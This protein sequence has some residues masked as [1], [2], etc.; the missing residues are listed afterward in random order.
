MQ[1]MLMLNSRVFFH[2]SMFMPPPP[3]LNT[4]T[5]VATLSSSTGNIVGN[6]GSRKSVHFRFGSN[7][8]VASVSASSSADSFESSS[9]SH[10]FALLME[11]EG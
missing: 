5:S 3:L 1:S 4:S 7:R 10:D 8:F 6:H 2:G 11:V 9:S